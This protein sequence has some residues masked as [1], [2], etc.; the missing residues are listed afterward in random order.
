M[1][2]SVTPF[3]MFE[4]EAEAAMSLYAAVV[5]NTRIVALELHADGPKKGAVSHGLLSL[6]GQTVRFFDSPAPHAFKLTASFSFFLE[7]SSEEELRRLAVA[8]GEGQT[9]MPIDNYGFSRLF[10]WVGD[11]FGVTWQLN[12]A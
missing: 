8:L 4:G 11:K 6:A 3:L 5:P 9:F 12:L 2:Q 7:C 1:V 10:A